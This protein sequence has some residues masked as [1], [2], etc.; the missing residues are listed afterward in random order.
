MTANVT[1]TFPKG[2][3][4]DEV[5]AA[6]VAAM[7]TQ[8]Y[9]VDGQLVHQEEMVNDRVVITDTWENEAKLNAFLHEF[10]LPAFESAGIPAPKIQVR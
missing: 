7:T 3:R 1:I 10:A 2:V 8:D 5:N 4:I 6:L 9:Q